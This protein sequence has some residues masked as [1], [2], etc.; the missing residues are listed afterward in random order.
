MHDC[1]DLSILNSEPMLKGF[2]RI[3]DHL[4]KLTSSNTQFLLFVAY[5]F[6]SNAVGHFTTVSMTT[7]RFYKTARKF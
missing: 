1:L 7:G 2:A 3:A 5:K 4:C 6:S